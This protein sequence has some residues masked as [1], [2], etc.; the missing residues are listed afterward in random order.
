MPKKEF[1]LRLTLAP[2]GCYSH[3][4]G[5]AMAFTPHPAGGQW[6]PAGDPN[7]HVVLPVA[8]DTAEKP[9]WRVREA[10]WGHCAVS[11]E[12]AA[13]AAKWRQSAGALP[14][15]RKE[16]IADEL[17]V[18]G[19]PAAAE[20][21]DVKEAFAPYCTVLRVRL[22]ARGG[23]AVQLGGL[24]DGAGVL[25]RVVEETH[26]RAVVLGATLT[27]LQAHTMVQVGGAGGSAL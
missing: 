17:W 25:Q 23:A 16:D 27:V 18:T 19:L 22:D 10:Y 5:V 14:Q 9:T 21:R 2:E 11:E 6:R 8:G 13:L 20:E 7:L 1:W 15:Q 24:Q 3:V 12:G 4:N 26:R